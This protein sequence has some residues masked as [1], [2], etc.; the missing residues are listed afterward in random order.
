MFSIFSAGPRQTALDRLSNNDT[1][2]N[3]VFTRTFIKE[4]QEPGANLVQ[5]AQ[6]TRRIVSEM[7]ETVKHKQVPV[8]FDQMVDDVFLNGV[9]QGAAPRLRPGRPSRC[10]RSRRCRRSRCRAADRPTMR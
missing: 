9:A 10:S 4:L 5:V 7:A 2:P 3:S 6:R 1:N 8:Y